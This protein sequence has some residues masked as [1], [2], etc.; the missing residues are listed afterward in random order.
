VKNEKDVKARVKKLLDKHNWFWFMPPANGYG[1]AGISDIIALKDG[2]FLAIETKFG[3]NKPTALQKGFLDSINAENGFGFVVNDSNIEQLGSFLEAFATAI[4][5]MGSK[6]S[7][8]PEI[9]ARQV[10]AIAALTD[11][12]R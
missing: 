8:P 12:I 9:M 7:V 2:T 1:K 4:E 10:D 3:S 11:L 5:A 6:Q